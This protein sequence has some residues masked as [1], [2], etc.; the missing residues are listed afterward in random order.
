MLS[1]W[2][3]N[4]CVLHNSLKVPQRWGLLMAYVIYYSIWY[5]IGIH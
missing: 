1:L 2:W 4:S 3:L 5:F